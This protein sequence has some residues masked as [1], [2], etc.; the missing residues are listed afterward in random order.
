MA[1]KKKLTRQYQVKR[2]LQGEFLRFRDSKG[3]LCKP[4][5]RKKLIVEI[6]KKNEKG[7]FRKTRKY[8]NKISKNKPVAH[9]FSKRA[10]EVWRFRNEY[11]YRV[12]EPKTLFNKKTV[13]L[14]ARIPLIDGIETKLSEML[15]FQDLRRK[16]KL[17]TKIMW[18]HRTKD[19]YHVKK[20]FYFRH[21]RDAVVYELA[22]SIANY[23]YSQGERM[24]SLKDSS[25]DELKYKSSI[26]VTFT[27]V[28]V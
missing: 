8:F 2:V 13:R 21:T 17:M 27:W 22:A 6:W 20:D 10:L 16:K 11:N 25:R 3:R 5:S 15:D 12:R 28:G 19:G 24:S 4:D 7:K 23:V 1:K 18:Q 14:S 26:T 9:K